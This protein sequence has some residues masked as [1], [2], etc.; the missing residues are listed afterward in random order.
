M[1]WEEKG[2]MRVDLGRGIEGGREGKK[3][4][5]VVDF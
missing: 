2:G 3:K 4:E 5:R 1:R